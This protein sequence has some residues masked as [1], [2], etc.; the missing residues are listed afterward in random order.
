MVYACF[1][2]DSHMPPDHG[3]RQLRS[4]G[5][6]PRTAAKAAKAAQGVAAPPQ[7]LTQTLTAAPPGLVK[8][9]MQVPFTV[10][11][12]GRDGH[13][14]IGIFVFEDSS[15]NDHGVFSMDEVMAESVL[16]IPL[17]ILDFRY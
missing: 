14:H 11:L 16:R 3:R 8:A 9:L 17:L 12:P 4:H 2:L 10:C 7:E 13:P 15:K 6:A 5:V 1:T